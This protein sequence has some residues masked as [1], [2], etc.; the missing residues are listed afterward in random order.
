MIIHSRMPVNIQDFKY[1]NPLS[2]CVPIFN[3]KNMVTLDTGVKE[4]I[5]GEGERKRKKRQGRK[6]SKGGRELAGDTSLTS[7]TGKPETAHSATW[8]LGE[9]LLPE[10]PPKASWGCP[11][12]PKPKIQAETARAPASPAVYVTSV[13]VMSHF[14][15]LQRREQGKDSESPPFYREGN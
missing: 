7:D 8:H 12:H 2:G 10:L 6:E 5:R 15:A 9:V 1:S 14:S 4:K 13:L 11:P 3:L